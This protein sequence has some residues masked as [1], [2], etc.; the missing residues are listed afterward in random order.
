M[1]DELDESVL[2]QMLSIYN[3]LVSSQ[4]EMGL[5]VKELLYENLWDLYGGIDSNEE[6]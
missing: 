1:L 4:V 6:L 5:E 3:S 2:K